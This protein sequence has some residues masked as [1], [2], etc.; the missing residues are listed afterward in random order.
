MTAAHKDG[1]A[2]LQL[3]LSSVLT[4]PNLGAALAQMERQGT[5]LRTGDRLND[6]FTS[7]G[8]PLAPGV[9]VHAAEPPA[10]GKISFGICV[11]LSEGGTPHC[12]AITIQSPISFD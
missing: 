9:D 4:S 12:T 5:S 3:G 10:E 2:R 8:V 1:F 7:G 11:T 6:M